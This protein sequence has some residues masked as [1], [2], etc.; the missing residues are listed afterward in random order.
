MRAAFAAAPETAAVASLLQLGVL[1]AACAA[2]A[3]IHVRKR[4]RVEPGRKGRRVRRGRAARGPS[5]EP[6]ERV[7]TLEVVSTWKD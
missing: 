1:L 2:A 3:W 7:P 4:R 6:K 5:V